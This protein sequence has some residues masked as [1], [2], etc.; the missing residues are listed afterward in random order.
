MLSFLPHSANYAFYYPPA[1]L[2]ISRIMRA[3]FPDL[4]QHDCRHQ[5]FH[6]VALFLAD[7]PCE[8]SSTNVIGEILQSSVP[9]GVSFC[10]MF[11]RF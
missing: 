11:V 5:S 9:A 6:K 8:H 3:D 7:P 10:T 4:L 1:I 2:G